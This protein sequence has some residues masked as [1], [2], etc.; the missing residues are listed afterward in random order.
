MMVVPLRSRRDLK[1][2]DCV[3]EVGIA[4]VQGIIVR[5][6]G[7]GERAANF[8]A[9]I[10]VGWDIWSGIVIAPGGGLIEEA[11]RQGGRGVQGAT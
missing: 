9:G 6:A 1:E 8:I 3:T 11:D 10:V 2:R 5:P 4:E 7:D